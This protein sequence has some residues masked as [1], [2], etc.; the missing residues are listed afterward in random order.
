MK[1]KAPALVFAYGSN[2]FPG[3]MFERCPSARFVERATIVGTR[4]VFAGFSARWRGAV[5]GLEVAKGQR[6]HGVIYSMSDADLSQ[7]DRV[8][9]HP[10]YYLRVGTHV[11]TGRGYT[12]C[13]TYALIR[14]NEFTTPPSEEYATRVRDGYRAWNLPIAAL[15]GAIR[16]AERAQR[17]RSDL[18]LPL[19]LGGAP[20]RRK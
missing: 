13:F 8:E 1:T 15:D 14:T 16:R 9:G 18:W 19:F 2:L 4:L 17:E 7:L 11:R 3:Q 6:T 20:E 10:S 12:R 5:A